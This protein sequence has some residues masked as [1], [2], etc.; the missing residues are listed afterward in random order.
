MLAVDLHQ[1]FSLRE[2][3]KRP[4]VCVGVCQTILTHKQSFVIGEK[5]SLKYEETHSLKSR[6]LEHMQYSN[7]REKKGQCLC[8]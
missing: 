6:S 7:P 2:I 1:I 4:R 3:I 5:K 8:I